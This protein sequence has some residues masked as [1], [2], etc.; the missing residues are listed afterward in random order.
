[1]IYFNRDEHIRAIEKA[2]PTTFSPRGDQCISRGDELG[3][4]MGGVIL[5]DFT[6]RGGSMSMHVASVH[7]RWLCRD[8]LWVVFDYV[9]SQLG[10]RK[11][12]AQIHS[13]NYKSL[14]FTRH[15]GFK[16]VAVIP[17]AFPDGDMVVKQLEEHNCRWHHLT[18]RGIKRGHSG[19]AVSAGTAG[20]HA[21]RASV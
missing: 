16:L 17:E 13:N 7:P 11:V 2:A 4:F 14:H 20:L 21:D 18:P 8:L 5:T 6:G 12:F 9:F 19:Q 3:R 1:M 10:C 15:L